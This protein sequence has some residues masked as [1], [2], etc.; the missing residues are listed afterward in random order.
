MASLFRRSLPLAA[1][2]R[3]HAVRSIIDVPRSSFVTPQDYDVL[4]TDITNE[5]L[6]SQHLSDVFGHAYLSPVA[7]TEQPQWPLRGTLLGAFKRPILSASVT[8]RKSATKVFFIVDTG[9]WDALWVPWR[10]LD[11]PPRNSTLT[12]STISLLSPS[13]F[14]QLQGRHTAS[15]QSKQPWRWVSRIRSWKGRWWT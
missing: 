11:D 9:T 6:K 2:R 8:R 12:P 14:L 7:P 5:S 10:N 4:L 15:F 3:G 13:L 1:S